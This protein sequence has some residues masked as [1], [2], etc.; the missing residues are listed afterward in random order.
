MIRYTWICKD[1]KF[2]TEHISEMLDH[3][4]DL[5]IDLERKEI[6]G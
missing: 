6:L 5:H 2:S 4:V 1:C 3:I